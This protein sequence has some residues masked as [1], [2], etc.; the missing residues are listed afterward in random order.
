[1]LTKLREIVA[2]KITYPIARKIAALNI[3]PNTITIIGF[4]IATLYLPLMAYGRPLLALLA[5]VLSGAMDILDGAVAKVTGKTTKLGSFLDS[6]LDRIEDIIFIFGLRFLKINDM[7]I[8]SFLA[9]SLMISYMRAKGESLGLKVEGKGVVERAER[10]ILIILIIMF[11]TI[12]YNAALALM[13]L[14]IIL[15]LIS[16]IQRF[17]FITKSLKRR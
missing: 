7:L 3:S 1:M 14:A 16:F 12:S 15:S 11:S 4:F 8:Y 13:Y 6:T 5:I 2:K 10:I 9:L 17:Y